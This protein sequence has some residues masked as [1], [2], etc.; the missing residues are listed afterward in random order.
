ML[1]YLAFFKD[2]CGPLRLF[3]YVTFR[4]GGAAAT[5]FLIVV[6]FGGAFARM[7]RKM[8]LRAA[9][10]YQGLLPPEMLDKRK[11]STPCMGGVLMILSVLASSL[12]WLRPDGVIGWILVGGMLLFGILGFVDDAL[13]V[14]RQDRDGLP[15][16]PKLFF[17]FL[18]A[19]LA[20]TALCFAPETKTLMKEFYVP[21]LKTPLF[22]DSW[23]IPAFSVLAIAVMVN[24]V[25]FTDGKDGLAAGCTIFCSFTFA[26]FTYLMGHKIFAEYLGLSY[27]NGIEEAV[28]FAFAVCGCCVGFLWHNC[29]PA[30]MFMGDTG[31]LALGGAISLLAVLVRQEI[32][33][34]V[35]G[36]VFS[37]EFASV[38]LQRYYYKM[39]K[40]RI[41]LCSPIHHHFERLGWTETQ[42]VVRFWILSGLFSLIALG[43]LKL[44]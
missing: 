11:N 8:N 34:F 22:K 23:L 27:I 16:N 40:K 10:R 13:K 20:V 31:S 43:T 32:L 5:A 42:I 30:A 39:T 2:H 6:C 3:D 14:F 21:F 44:R 36:G 7:L 28:V 33:M 38:I 35:V 29:H 17:Q 24:A 15:E 41:F 37:M 4:A 9:D 12:L 25:N 19:A 26:V 18:I 1:Y